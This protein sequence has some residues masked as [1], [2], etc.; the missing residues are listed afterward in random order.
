MADSRVDW[1]RIRAEY[2]RGG[3]SQRDLATKH[4][5]PYSTLRDRALRESWATQ[6]EQVRSR[7]G[8]ELPAKLAAVQLSEAERATQQDLDILGRATELAGGL[9]AGIIDPTG[10]KDWAS[11]YRALQ[12]CRRLALGIPA[13]VAAERKNEG[14]GGVTFVPD[15]SDAWLQEAQR[16]RA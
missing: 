9:L 16:G 13:P 7:V 4:G 12:A 8:A 14:G 3:I 11:A 6:S 15:D 2:V 10:L 5:I 1:G